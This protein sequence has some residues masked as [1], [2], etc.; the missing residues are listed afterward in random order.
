M[1]LKGKYAR[2]GEMV[3]GREKKL[4]AYLVASIR[5]GNRARWADLIRLRTPRLMAHATRLLADPEAARDV[6]QDSWIDIMRGLYGL[7]D[8]DAF[9]PWA[10]R[11]VARRVAA[12]IKR[13]QKGRALEDELQHEPLTVP[14]QSAER[15]ADAKTI[16]AAIASL[17]PKMQ[18]TMALFY[19]EDLTV[20]E[21]ATALDVPIGTVKTR[22]MHAR[23]LL[24]HALK[25]DGHDKTG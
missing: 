1:P 16:R 9:L 19:L 13:R 18:A 4:E 2:L 12:E 17:P 8:I 24:L 22:L 14:L 3:K 21:V 6:V 11:I 23:S 7:R 20:A 5:A 25:G 15:S 10:L